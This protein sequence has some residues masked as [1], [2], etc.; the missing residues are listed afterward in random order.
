[1]YVI[2]IPFRC[3]VQN[4][5]CFVTE[6]LLL[7][8][9]CLSL[10]GSYY[11]NI[12]SFSYSLISFWIYRCHQ[13]T[14]DFRT[15]LDKWF[16]IEGYSQLRWAYYFIPLLIKCR[17]STTVFFLKFLKCI[18]HSVWFRISFMFNKFVLFFYYKMKR[19]F[20]LCDILFGK[21]VPM[22]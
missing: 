1:M 4:S 9:S 18:F 16:N 7:V 17:V 12:L 19:N 15:N 21:T 20:W 14:C 8:V 10:N 5:F 6:I 2:N 11:T 3:T 22:M 13:W